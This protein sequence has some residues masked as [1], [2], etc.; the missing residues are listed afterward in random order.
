MS[1]TEKKRDATCEV[2]KIQLDRAYARTPN[3]QKNLLN[4]PQRIIQVTFPIRMDSG[5]MR[6]FEGYRV[7]YN[8][9]RGPTKGGLR[10]H[11]EVDLEEIKL[12]A[13]LMALKCACVHIP[14]GGAK[15]GVTC[16]PKSLSKTE[17]ERVSRG[18][19][20]AIASFIG[21]DKDIPAPDV[22]TNAE[23]MGWMVDEFETIM[24]HKSP[25]VITGKPLPLGGSKGREYSTSLGGA[26][27]LRAH[28]KGRDPKTVSIA[29]QGFGNVGMHIAR[30]LDEWG[31]TVVA[32][33]TSKGG[34]YNKKGLDMKKVLAHHKAKGCFEDAT[35]G[36]HILNEEL[37]ELP[38]DVLVPAALE[39]VITVSN[40]KKIKA[41]LILEMANAP[42]TPD[43]DALLTIP[44]LPDLLVNSGGVVV[45]YFEW[46][47][48]LQNYYW[49]EET[50][51]KELERFMIDA[52]TAVKARVE[53]DKGPYREAAY[54]IAVE[55]IL[56]AEKARGRLS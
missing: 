3:E 48:N 27:I 2:C 19:I 52:Y 7:Q 50:V 25:G 33:S 45:S 22:N 21:P 47:Q 42:I 53:K 34:L 37:L 18:Y 51:L 9:A 55:R 15:G 28:L 10:F 5:A 6:I 29:V 30:I 44:V 49:S 13:F 14:Y 17:L 35:F 1:P 8:D 20:R 46:V 23:I 43:A 4:K 39:N 16:D 54:K 36:E 41:K 38:V 24:Q 11:P 32:V 56:E 26:M 12:L 40:V 31:Y